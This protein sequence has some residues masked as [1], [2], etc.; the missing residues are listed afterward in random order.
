[1]QT[2]KQEFDKPNFLTKL[3]SGLEQAWRSRLST[4]CP[5]QSAASRES[6]IR[7]LGRVCRVN[8][9]KKYHKYL[10]SC[11]KCKSNSE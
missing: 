2:L 3:P 4:D 10:I 11:E 7:W 1:M 8:Y 6:I 9:V 5:E